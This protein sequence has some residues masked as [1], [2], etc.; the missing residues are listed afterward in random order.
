M[1]RNSP[2]WLSRGGWFN[3]PNRFQRWFERTVP[4]ALAAGAFGDILLTAR[5]P[6]LNQGGEFLHTRKAVLNSYEIQTD[7]LPRPNSVN[8]GFPRFRLESH[9][10]KFRSSLRWLKSPSLVLESWA[11][12]WPRISP[13]A[14]IIH[15]PSS[16]AQPRKRKVGNRTRRP[17][18]AHAE[19]RRRGRRLRL[20][21]RGQR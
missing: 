18:C 20:H 11:T 16:T 2:P 21:L 8:P 1:C 13:N 10:Q 12:P 4:S 14:V 3:S 5:P 17:I 15:S 6:R 7:T 9:N 19:G